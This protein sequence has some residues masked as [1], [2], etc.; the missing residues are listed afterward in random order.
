MT[1]VGLLIVV[2]VFG[3]IC[4]CVN[5]LPIQ[6]PFKTIALVILVVI[7]LLWLLGSFGLFAAGPVVRIR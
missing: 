4:W 1:L 7:L 6:Q 3:L 2:I 5:A